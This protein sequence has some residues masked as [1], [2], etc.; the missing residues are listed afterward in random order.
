MDQ[1]KRL[2]ENGA[3]G[4][5]DIEIYRQMLHKMETYVLKR[6]LKTIQTDLE[7]MIKK[8]GCD[9]SNMYDEEANQEE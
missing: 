8:P 7:E 3:Q 1:A 5:S 9:A 2:K 4:T 6:T